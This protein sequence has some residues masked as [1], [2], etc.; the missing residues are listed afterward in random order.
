MKKFLLALIFGAV[1]FGAVAQAQEQQGKKISE[2]PAVTSFTVIDSVLYPVVQGGVTKKMYGY[3]LVQ[4][5]QNA[6]T[7]EQVAGGYGILV[8]SISPHNFAIV[9]DTTVIHTSAYNDAQYAG[10]NNVW[11]TDGTSSAAAQFNIAAGP[12]DFR[13]GSVPLGYIGGFS[14]AGKIAF[15]YNTYSY[16]DRSITIGKSIANYGDS[17]FVVG[18][19][20]TNSIRR[21]AVVF[22][23]WMNS[24][25]MNLDSASGS[26]PNVVGVDANGDW[27]RYANAGGGGSDNLDDVTGRDSTTTHNIVISGDNKSYAV[28]ST[29]TFGEAGAGTDAGKGYLYVAKADGNCVNI[30]PDSLGASRNL[31]APNESG[32]IAIKKYKEYVANIFP[33]S[34]GHDAPVV[35]VINNEIGTITWSQSADGEFFANCTNCFTNGKTAVTYTAGEVTGDAPIFSWFPLDGEDDTII[36]QTISSLSG[37]ATDGTVSWFQASFRVYK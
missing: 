11:L 2:L 33:S 31:F 20:F 16:G 8:D 13:E 10:T 24:L 36:T 6:L 9:I 28:R 26:A 3:Q 32:V 30:L 19:N 4:A 1:S 23:D 29:T 21:R 22:V 18:A 35:Q 34:T 37:Y 17:S 7:R 15:G 25:H 12:F 27:H 5:I 14:G